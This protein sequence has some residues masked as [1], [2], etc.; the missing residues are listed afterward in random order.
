MNPLIFIGIYAIGCIIAYICCLTYG[1]I[2]E[3]R[4]PGYNFDDEGGWSLLVFFWPFTIIALA[5]Y[6][7]VN[8]VSDILSDLFA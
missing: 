1:K 6:F 5:I 8:K 3:K 7:L 4:Y 2:K